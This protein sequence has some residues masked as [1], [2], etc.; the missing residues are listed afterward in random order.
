MFSG[1]TALD[2]YL[3]MLTEWHGDKQALFVSRP[4]LEALGNAVSESS[5]YRAAMKT[6]A[7]PLT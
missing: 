6:H 1:M 5:S 2:F 3:T 7:L 4:K